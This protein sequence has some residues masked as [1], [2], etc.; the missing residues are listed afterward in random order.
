[1]FEEV[2]EPFLPPETP[3]YDISKRELQPLTHVSE[4]EENVIVVVDLPCVKKED[5]KLSATENMLKVE[6]SM[7]ECVR[8]SPY[9]TIQKETEFDV[10]RKTIRLPAP[11]EPE[12][13]KARFKNGIL[14]VIL[15]KKITGYRIPVE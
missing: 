11:V 14:E 4:S 7:K 3:M 13:A 12:K 15:P 8:L 10:F 9:G 1:M 2:M 5:I 6:A